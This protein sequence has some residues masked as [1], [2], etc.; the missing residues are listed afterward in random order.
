MSGEITRATAAERPG[1]PRSKRHL[2]GWEC[3]LSLVSN[4]GASGRT[5]EI[6]T[7]FLVPIR[8]FLRNNQRALNMC[9]AI[10]AYPK[11]ANGSSELLRKSYIFSL[12]ALTVS[13]WADSHSFLCFGKERLL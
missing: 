2:G 13:G 3:C 8:Q 12:V 7:F 6:I 11:Q 10:A 4:F 5:R 9:E 1:P